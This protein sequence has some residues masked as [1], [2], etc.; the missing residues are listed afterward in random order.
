MNDT[1]HSFFPEDAKK[2]GL[3]KAVL[4]YNIKFW[5]ETTKKRI[6]S[7]KKENIRKSLNNI[8]EHNG[9]LYFWAYLKP[10]KMKER[11]PYIS[12]RVIRNNLQKMAENGVVIS[13]NFS[14]GNDN[15]LK[16]Y[17][18]AEFEIT[19]HETIDLVKKMAPE[20]FGKNRSED[21]K[22]SEECSEQFGR[23]S[24]TI[25]KDKDTKEKDNVDTGNHKKADHGKANQAN[26]ELNKQISKII[27]VFEKTINPM[28]KYGNKTERTASKDLITKFGFD[29]T[30][31]LAYLAVK[32][33]SMPYGPSITTPW[34]LTRS[35]G[36]L[37]AFVAK[38]KQLKEKNSTIDQETLQKILNS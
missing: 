34:E 19:D 35:L 27:E 18:I 31:E 30:R 25:Y 29:K 6:K 21:I 5:C 4:L 3:T 28:I 26:V 14:N 15:R 8:H 38:E 1:P 2:Y 22:G 7:Y 17:T 24:R 36:K 16:W 32:A 10:D 12:D 11:C 37:Q 20:K 9:K 13:D 33:S 23:N